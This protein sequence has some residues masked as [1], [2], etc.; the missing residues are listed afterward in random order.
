MLMPWMTM[1]WCI[2]HAQHRYS[3]SSDKANDKYGRQNKKDD[4]QVK[5]ALPYR[6]LCMEC[7]ELSNEQRDLKRENGHGHTHLV[8]R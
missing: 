6:I 1:L 5:N 8:G 3:A 4:I 7:S 2:H